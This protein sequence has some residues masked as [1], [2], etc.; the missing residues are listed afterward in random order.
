MP[1]RPYPSPLRYPGG[2]LKVANYVKLLFERNNLLDGD[3]AEPYA[4][5][6]SVALALLFG[7]YAARIFINDLDPAIY[8]FWR[9]VLDNPEG[10]KRLIADTPMTM[11]EWYNQRKI[12]LRPD[13]SP[14]E[15]AF[16]TFYLNRANRS[17]IILGGVIGGKQQTGNWKL[18]ARF[19]R[20]ELTQRIE[21]IARHSDRISVTNYDAQ[22][23]LKKVVPT[24]STRSLTYLDPPYYV[25]GQGLY[26]NAYEPDDH[27]AVATD[28]AALTK[29]WL[30]S[31]DNAPE[32]LALYQRFR[33]LEYG[34]SYSAQERRQGGEVMFFSEGLELPGGISNPSKVPNKF[35]HKLPF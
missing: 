3:Y 6:S 16:A 22:I 24:M 14:L 5:G 12:F 20:A 15:L 8:T 21:K 34:L 13:S 9:T 1:T 10:L 28:V 26:A 7:H 19:N 11:D 25:K 27:A 33:P 4:G 2:K 18:D 23:F 35:L 29:P 31:Y 32:I 17:G 30:V